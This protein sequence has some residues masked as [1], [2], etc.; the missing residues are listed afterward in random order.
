M[1]LVDVDLDVYIVD[2]ISIDLS[3]AFNVFDKKKWDARKS[4]ALLKANDLINMYLET[5]P[6]YAQLL[7]SIKQRQGS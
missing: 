1:H 7:E 2:R 6:F 4:K 3:E 5:E